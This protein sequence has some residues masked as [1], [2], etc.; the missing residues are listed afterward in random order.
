MSMFFLNRCLFLTIVGCKILLGCPPVIR[1][2]QRLRRV[3][4]LNLF[5]KY[6]NKKNLFKSKS[7]PSLF[8]SFYPFDD[9]QKI[10][11][12][13]R[14]RPAVY[15]FFLCSSI[16]TPPGPSETIISS[17][18]MTDS[19]WKKSYFKKSRSGL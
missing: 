5:K 1:V 18:P 2:P 9:K 4:N 8:F 11:T 13:R 6:L 10:S 7:F 16:E 17:P 19:V 12:M 15:H 14:T 3:T